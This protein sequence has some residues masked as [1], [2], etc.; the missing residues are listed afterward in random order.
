MLNVIIVKP[1]KYAVDGYVDRFRRGFMPN[2]TLYHLAAMTPDIVGDTAI[3]VTTIDE[4]IETDLAYLGRLHPTP[5]QETLVAFAG[6][7]SHQLN[8]TLDL[9]AFA[10][11]NGV[12]N[13]V[14]GGPHPMTCDT[15]ALEGRGVSFCRAEAELVWSRILDDSIRG[16]LL[17]T[18]GSGERWQ[19]QLDPPVVQ[20]PSEKEI[21]RYAAQM[22]GVYPARGCPYRCTFC[23]VIKLAGHTVRAQPIETTMATLRA[24]KAGGVLMIHFTT[25][26]FN[27]YPE[28]P[29]MLQAMIDESINLPF[30]VQCDAQIVR[31]PDLVE[32]LARAGCYQMFLGF[33]SLDETTLLDVKKSQN[34]PDQYGE[35]LRMCDDFGIGVHFSNIIGFPNDTRASIE[36]H[37]DTVRR[38]RPE[39]AT[40]YILTP[41]P[42]TEMY[43][44]YRSQGLLTEANLDRYDATFPTWRHPTLGREE[45]LELLHTCHRKFYSAPD[46]V[47]KSLRWAWR[48]RQ[49][50]NI[51]RKIATP[52]FS[53]LSRLAAHNRQH[54]LSGGIGRTTLDHCSNYSELRRSTFGFNLAPLP[55]SLHGPSA[56]S[57]DTPAGENRY[58]GTEPG[59]PVPPTGVERLVAARI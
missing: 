15:S 22:F 39:V 23:S 42:G 16:T 50:D 11:R 37:L 20:P 57:P 35:I 6:V 29:Q 52:A 47:T 19:A 58:P 1:S 33:E 12:R 2:T 18:Y 38:L 3:R 44:E 24:A 40:F 51:L 27:K 25:D 56:N 13:I 48:N 10:R 9:A 4:Y 32:L 28:A 26:N 17:P 59:E 54:P 30:F 36:S 21:C 31:Q 55:E 14:V 53:F 34:R 41:F 7:Q 49:S 5:G 46:V 43:D 8:R 45:L